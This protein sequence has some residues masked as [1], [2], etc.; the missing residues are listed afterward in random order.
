MSL[1]N[2]STESF[3]DHTYEE[4]PKE[5]HAIDDGLYDEDWLD[6]QK[7]N[8]DMSL[9]QELEQAKEEYKTTHAQM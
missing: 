7:G 5:V 1:K 2:V 9:I 6:L 8:V 3:N 4:I